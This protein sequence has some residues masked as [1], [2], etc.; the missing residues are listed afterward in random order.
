MQAKI[1]AAAGALALLLVLS[2]W[3]ATVLSELSQSLAAIVAVKTWILK[4][5]ILLVPAMALAGGSGFSLGKG[6]KSAIVARKRLRMKIIAANGL[7]VLV[8]SAVFLATKAD[9]GVVRLDVCRRSGGRTD[10]GRCQRGLD[11]IEYAGR[12]GNAAS[13]QGATIAAWRRCLGSPRNVDHAAV[14]GLRAEYDTAAFAVPGH[15][16]H[17]ALAGTTQQH[18]LGIG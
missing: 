14:T 3:T 8:P 1:H 15:R 2:F 9:G 6:W 13:T 17:S 5:M 16:G 7:L 12:L 11:G 10:R 4:G 18:L